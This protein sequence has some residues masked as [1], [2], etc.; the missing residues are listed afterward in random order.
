MP[1]LALAACSKSEASPSSDVTRA[2][3]QLDQLAAEVLMNSG[4]PGLAVAVVHQG[5]TVYAKGFGVRRLGDSTPI[6]AHTVFQLASV[7]KPIG[8]T[9]VAAQVGKGLISWDTP[10]QQHLPWLS[11][12]DPIA[13]AQVTVGDLYAHRSGLPDH[14]GDELEALGYDRR[15]ILE[16]LH[17]LPTAPLRSRYAYTNFGM[18]AAAQ[19]VAVASN[20]NWE[21][22]SDQVLYRPLGMN[23]TS[24]RYTDFMARP[25]RASP[26]IWRNGVFQPGPP[27]RTDP[28]S[29]AGGVSS[30]V[31][32]M[33]TWMTLV[34]NEGKYQDQ[35]IIPQEALLPAISPQFLSSPATQNSPASHYGYGFIVS[36][37]ASGK[38]QLTHSGAFLLGAATTFSL[39][40]EA[41]TG[42]VVLTNAV[43][44]GAAE[45]LSM[46]YLDLV[47]FGKITRD[48]LALY[49]TAL[50][51]ITAPTGDL[52]GKPFPN[53]PAPSLEPHAYVGTYANTYYGD[54]KIESRGG[55]L[56]L[57][58]SPAGQEF[59]LLHWD[60]NV[61]VFE[62]GG[63]LA[64]PDSRSAVRFAVSPGGMMQ[65]LEIEVF[66]GNG[67]GTWTRR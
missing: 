12:Q 2:V 17:L 43:P 51:S 45:A 39:L 20:T 42:I 5:K 60:G 67:L 25:N 37:S 16:R 38:T 46:M 15:Q 26:H 14:A 57:V 9:V 33:A 53:H 52:S 3:A 11:L 56:T 41:D 65:G 31:L 66:N 36:T 64:S 48:W 13:S 40:P 6:D 30:N 23:A 44:V 35:Q 29:P 28:E 1:L 58:M 50:A 47:Q 55:Q 49:K 8:A 19:S 63:E 24:S 32:D 54:A 18:T 59:P 34:L 27:S 7:S 4:V 62:P 21:S 22:L 61:F 10:V